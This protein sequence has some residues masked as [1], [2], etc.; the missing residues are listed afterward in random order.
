MTKLLVR[1]LLV[2]GIIS[3]SAATPSTADAQSMCYSCGQDGGGH[4]C[5]YGT[6][7]QWARCEAVQN[8]CI[9]QT[10]CVD[11]RSQGAFAVAPDGYIQRSVAAAMLTAS[12]LLGLEQCAG[13]RAA[14]SVQRGPSAEGD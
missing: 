8:G 3:V 4:V 1:L 14:L 10:P 11:T 6:G 9:F 13:M 5:I 7:L 12:G 2:I